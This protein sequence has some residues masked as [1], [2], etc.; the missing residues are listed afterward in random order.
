LVF[1]FWFLH[2]GPWTVDC[3]LSTIKELLLIAAIMLGS[4]PRRVLFVVGATA[5]LL[6]FIGIH[7]AWDSVTYITIGELETPKESEDQG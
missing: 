3:R 6:L 2:F 1:G 4:D 5:I 7:N